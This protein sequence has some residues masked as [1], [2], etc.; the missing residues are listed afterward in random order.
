MTDRTCSIEGCDQ[1]F[2]M[3]AGLCNMHY[4]RL[5]RRGSIELPQRVRLNRRC[6][7][8]GCDA[9]HRA[10]GYCK[11]HYLR[12]A[13]YGTVN[14]R[15]KYESCS[16]T[17]CITEVRSA[18]TPYCEMHYGRLRRNGH[19]DYVG[20]PHTDD[21]TYRTVHSRLQAERGPASDY[22]CVDCLGPADDWSYDNGD[23]AERVD[24]KTTC[25]YS[26]DADHY[27][28]RCK[29]CHYRFDHHKAKT[30]ADA[31]RGKHR[32]RTANSYAPRRA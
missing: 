4:L 21:P 8:D 20:P 24:P 28:P 1:T 2:R 7:V 32:L 27:E 31:L 23:S 30:N 14:L 29:R 19:L 26:L 17:G 10:R 18:G 25:A 3:R 16:V 6:S 9:R 11:V 13:Q 12:M 22:R 5:R 15:P